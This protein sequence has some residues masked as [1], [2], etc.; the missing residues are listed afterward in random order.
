[1]AD[2]FDGMFHTWSFK[3]THEGCKAAY[4]TASAKAGKR[5]AMLHQL[6]REYEGIKILEA[7]PY[8]SIAYTSRG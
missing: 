1:M 4:H 7:Y 3:F 2:R 5:D 8:A 6:A